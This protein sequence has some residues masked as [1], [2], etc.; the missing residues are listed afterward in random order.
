MKHM[1][2]ITK[3]FMQESRHWQARIPLSFCWVSC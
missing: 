2:H 3:F 1:S